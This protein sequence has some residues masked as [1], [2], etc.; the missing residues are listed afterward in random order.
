MDL[1][2]MLNSD[3]ASAAERAAASP[4]PKLDRAY[5]ADMALSGSRH[6][7]QQLPHLGTTFDSSGS[8]QQHHQSPYP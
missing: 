3:E 1:R 5:T 4:R 6:T 2:K 8:V 7:P